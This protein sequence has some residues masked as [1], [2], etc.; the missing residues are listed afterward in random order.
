[1]TS[2]PALVRRNKKASSNGDEVSLEEVLM[3]LGVVASRFFSGLLLFIT[4]PVICHSEFRRKSD[5]TFAL[6]AADLI[7]YG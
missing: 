1:M 5:K 6:P 4:G 2:P 7:Y 3:V